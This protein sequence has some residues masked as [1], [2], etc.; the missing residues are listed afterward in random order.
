[1]IRRLIVYVIREKQQPE[2]N[3]SEQKGKT[4]II[5]KATTRDKEDKTGTVPKATTTRDKEDKENTENGSGK[6]EAAPKKR[7]MAPKSM[8][9]P[10]SQGDSTPS[11]S[12]SQT[13]K[14]AK[15]QKE[16]SSDAEEEESSQEEEAVNTPPANTTTTTKSKASAKVSKDNKKS[17]E[18][19]EE[20]QEA[21]EG[22]K[23]TEKPTTQKPKR[24][25]KAVGGTEEGE[26]K[27][28]PMKKPMKR[29]KSEKAAG[30]KGEG[31]AKKRKKV[32]YRP[33]NLV[34]FLFVLLSS[35]P[36]FLNFLSASPP[37]LF[38]TSSTITI[39]RFI[40]SPSYLPLYSPSYLT[41]ALRSGGD[42][43]DQED[44]GEYEYHHP[45]EPLYSMCQAD[46]NRLHSWRGPRQVPSLL[47]PPSLILPL[48]F[49]F[50]SSPPSSPPPPPLVLEVINDCTR[51][52]A[53]SLEALQESVECYLVGLF[54]GMGRTRE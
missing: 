53:K 4:G 20:Q 29:K 33:G 42:A 43:R 7:T 12:S 40:P 8:R 3:K 5:S 6:K 32:H 1:M 28:K 36:S 45:Q 48:F 21:E 47:D 35:P 44:A 9:L 15:P 11:S 46:S 41:L 52:T 26:A 19:V 38:R 54:E 18:E 24:T 13:K 49:F 50:F 10:S 39:T 30:E 23:S 37:Y 14:R 2:K 34:P 25:K 17:T 27:E 22:E 31:V 51:F 16:R